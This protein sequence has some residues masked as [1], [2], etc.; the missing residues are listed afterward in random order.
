MFK[1]GL[2][3]SD[4]KRI[5]WTAVMAFIGVYATLAAGVG[6]IHNFDEGKAAV[7]SLLPAAIAA[8]I[9]AVKNGVLPETSPAK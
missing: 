5:A 2:T 9:S 8:A 7:L 1:L 3:A 6:D 4:L